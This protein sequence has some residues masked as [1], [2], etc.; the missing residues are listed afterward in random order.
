VNRALK[1]RKLEQGKRN[2]LDGSLAASNPY[3]ETNYAT[4]F[5]SLD[6]SVQVPETPTEVLTRWLCYS[7]I[8]YGIVGG[9]IS[10]LATGLKIFS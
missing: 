1:A 10:F 6:V 5:T 2:E 4:R 3:D 9:T 7:I 8:I